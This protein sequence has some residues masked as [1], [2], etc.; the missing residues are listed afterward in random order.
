MPRTPRAWPFC[1]IRPHVLAQAVQD[2]FPEAKLGIGP[3][4]K[5]GFYYDF[6]SP[7]RSTPRT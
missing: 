4:V 3:P 6:R 7:S 5:D 2:L 1:G